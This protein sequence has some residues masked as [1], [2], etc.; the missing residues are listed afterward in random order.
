MLKKQIIISF[1]SVL[2]IGFTGLLAIPFLTRMLNPEEMGK[3]FLILAIVSVMQIFDGLKPVITYTMN[4]KQYS[5][6]IYLDVFKKVNHLFIGGSSI[7]ILIILSLVPSISWIE[8]VLFVITFIFYSLMSVQWGILDTK[9]EIN[10]TSI[11]RS[12]GWIMTYIFFVIF[13]YFTLPVQFYIAA[14]LFMYIFLYAFFKFR[15][16]QLTF[17]SSIKLDATSSL[18]TSTLFYTTLKKS[19]EN[20]KIQIFAIILLSMDKILIPMIVGYQQF[21]FYAVQSELATKSYLINNTLRRV[22]FPYFAREENRYK[23]NY[24]LKYINVIFIFFLLIILMIGQ[25]GNEIIG[26]YAGEVYKEYGIIFSVLLLVFP[27]NILGAF[28][29]TVLHVN[30]DFKLHHVLYRN[31]A[32][33]SFPIFFIL[34]FLYGIQ[35]AALGL[36]I[37][38]SV[39]IYTYYKAVSRYLVNISFL[40]ILIITLLYI[41]LG[42]GVVLHKSVI[43]FILFVS[44]IFI[45]WKIQEESS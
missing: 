35:G 9:N 4:E 19:L 11:F 25:Y 14:L 27:A 17:T 39:D 24:Y 33:M 21:A 29:I 22:L 23:L 41:G 8:T 38:R 2:I 18:T 20:I 15:V 1:L 16:S 40:K 42:I 26:F 36:L 7:I 43:V 5:D 32:I 10:Y 3:L 13:A 31:A 45:F 12:L 6:K 28:G 37:S 44:L 30:G 34:T